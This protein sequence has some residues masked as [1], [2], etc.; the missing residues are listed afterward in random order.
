MNI[1]VTPRIFGGKEAAVWL[2]ID[3][4][5][6]NTVVLLDDGDQVYHLNA[7]AY[8]TLV[9]RAPAESDVLTATVENGTVLTARYDG[10]ETERRKAAA[11]AR[12]HRLFGKK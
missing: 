6:G 7:A 10:E 9:G 12:L 5:E 11:R 1:Y 3:R 8:E 2:C 4:I